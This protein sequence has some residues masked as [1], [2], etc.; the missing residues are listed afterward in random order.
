MKKSIKNML[1]PALAIIALPLLASC[2]KDL[3]S[4]PTL[5]EPTTFHLNTPALALG[6]N[7]YDLEKGKTINLTTSQPDYGFPLAT[8]YQ[9]QVS[10][11]KD[12]PTEDSYTTLESSYP[13]AN[14]NVDATEMNNAIVDMYQSQNSG[15]DP[16]GIVMPIYV[17]LRAHISNSERGYI[18]SN[19]VEI[20]KVVVGYVA[21]MPK[22]FYLAGPSIRKGENAKALAPVYGSTGEFYGIAYIGSDGKIN[23]GT[24]TKPSKGFD[25]ATIVNKADGVEVTKASD[26]SIHIN[27]SGWYAFHSV[28]VVNKKL[29]KVETTLNIHN[30]S[31]YIIGAC[32]G[33]A[34]DDGNANWALKAPDNASANWESPAFVG[35]GE[36]RAYIKI[37]GI[38]WWKT[39]FT[40]YK[41]SLYWRNVNIVDNWAKNVGADYSVVGSAGQKLYIDFD[42]D[43]G[44]VK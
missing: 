38:E 34:W 33:S 17:R 14:M 42:Y 32:A 31:A 24:N 21:T 39:E 1:F 26:G 18:N 25:D 3:D 43:N 9:V 28:V 13:T 22:A 40:L 36:L 19:I 4:N 10:L 12:F 8:T 11:S 7:T 15:K 20:P 44:S 6:G 41:G 2:N 29:N 23:W 30:A 5:E 27:K 16:S 35:G 37:P